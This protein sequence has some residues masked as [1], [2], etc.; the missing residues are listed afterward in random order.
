MKDQLNFTP[1]NNKYKNDEFPRKYD[2]IEVDAL[3][4]ILL[5]EP[6]LVNLKN[7]SS[8][9]T[10]LFR[11]VQLGNNNIAECLL[12]GGADPNLQNCFG[13]T[14]LHQAIENKNYKLINLLLEKNANPDIQ[15]QVLNN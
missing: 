12:E 6:N 8:G 14:P 9:T 5:N 2:K 4:K 15:Q 13:E 3:K 7:E 1:N 10:L 11:A